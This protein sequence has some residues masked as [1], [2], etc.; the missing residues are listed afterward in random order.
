M[1]KSCKQNGDPPVAGWGGA[2]GRATP[3]E[4]CWLFIAVAAVPAAVLK[5]EQG[6]HRETWKRQTRRPKR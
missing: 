5:G 3:S 1:C 2:W 4:P 6:T